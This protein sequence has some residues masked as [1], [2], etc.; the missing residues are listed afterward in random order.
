MYKENAFHIMHQK[1][2]FLLLLSTQLFIL[3][4]FNKKNHTDSF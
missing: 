2:V 1:P 4:L 3:L